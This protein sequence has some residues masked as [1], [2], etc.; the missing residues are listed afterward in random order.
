MTNQYQ[1]RSV[2]SVWQRQGKLAHN[3]MVSYSGSVSCLSDMVRT[4][5]TGK[6]AKINIFCIYREKKIKFG[7]SE[8]LGFPIRPYARLWR[9]NSLEIEKDSCV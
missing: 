8:S 6:N 7:N 1:V 4:Y 3:F 9:G 2:S 5:I